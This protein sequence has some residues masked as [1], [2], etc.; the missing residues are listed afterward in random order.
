[1]PKINVINCNIKGK[2]EAYAFVPLIFSRSFFFG[3]L[4]V[5]KNLNIIQIDI[6]KTD[7]QWDNWLTIWWGNQKD[8]DLDAKDIKKQ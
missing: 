7:L 8:W 3:N 1:M 5:L 2:I 6:N 4:L